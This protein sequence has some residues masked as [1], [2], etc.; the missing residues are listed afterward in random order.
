M[1]SNTTVTDVSPLKDLGKLKV[2]ERTPTL[3]S[4]PS[5]DNAWSG[6]PVALPDTLQR[7]VA[8]L[9]VG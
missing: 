4:H 5:G 7:A 3:P 2:L 8:D 1:S 9:V 6:K